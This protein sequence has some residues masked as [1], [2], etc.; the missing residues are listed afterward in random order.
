[1]RMSTTEASQQP[2]SLESVPALSALAYQELID[3]LKLQLEKA[4]EERDRLK[5]EIEEH[6]SEEQG[7]MTTEEMR[8][9]YKLR[10]DYARLQAHAIELMERIEIS[11]KVRF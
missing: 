7:E 3:S 2:K 11:D 10:E 9:L 5:M 6:Q 8:E 4:E 1:M